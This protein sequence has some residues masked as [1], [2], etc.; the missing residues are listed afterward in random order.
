MLRI[1]LTEHLEIIGHERADRLAPNLRCAVAEH[2]LGGGIEQFDAPAAINQDDAVH[3]CLGELPIA[4]LRVGKVLLRAHLLG[5]VPE[6]ALH[7]DHLPGGVGDRRLDDVDVDRLTARP[8]VLLDRVA[9]RAGVRD[10]AVVGDVLGGKLG[11][12]EV[13]VGLAEQLLQAMADGVAETL[14]GERET[15]VAILT[16]YIL[17]QTLYEGMIER[18]RVLERTLDVL[19]F[20]ELTDLIARR[21]CQRQQR[22]IGIFFGARLQ[23][24]TTASTWPP[25]RTGKASARCRPASAAVRQRG[26]LP[27]GLPR[28]SHSRGRGSRRTSSG[29]SAALG[30]RHC[31]VSARNSASDGSGSC[32]A[33]VHSRRPSVTLHHTPASKSSAAHSTASKSPAVASIAPSRASVRDTRYCAAQRFSASFCAVTSR[34]TSTAPLIAPLCSRSGRPVKLPQRPRGVPA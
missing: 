33:A 2:A 18:F 6:D 4:A 20:E 22:L 30:V 9:D 16:E 13:E 25:P 10:A 26:V 15:P 28:T 32:Q 24:S 1:R 34:Q 11:R 31:R 19:P 7:A 14:V 12:E 5:D 3:G 27:H 17:R 29:N 21:L 23:N 8:M